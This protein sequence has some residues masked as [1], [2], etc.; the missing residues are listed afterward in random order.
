M[1]GFH[2]AVKTA[3][4]HFAHPE[5]SL[6]A[7]ADE[8]GISKQ[9]VKKRID[10]ARELFKTY[11]QEP[12]VTLLTLQ[13]RHDDEIK[14]LREIAQNLRAHLIVAKTIIFLLSSFKEM[15]KQFFPKMELRRFAPGQKTY[16][17]DMCAKFLR[18]GGTIKDFCK[19]IG[20][21]YETISRWQA[22]Y[23][24]YGMAGLVDKKTRPHNFYRRIP[25]WLKEKL[26]LLF[27]QYP[28][29]TPYQYYKYIRDNPA[30]NYSLSLVTITKFKEVHA[31]KSA[32]EKERIKKRWAFAP[33]YSVWTVDFTCILKTP[34]YK[35]QLLTVSDQRSRFWFES[36]LF[37]ETSTEKVMDH[38]EDLFIKYGKPFMIKADNGPEFKME[39]KDSLNE[40]S[41]YLLNSPTYYGQFCG[42]HERIHR[43]LKDYISDFSSHKNIT[44]LVGEINNFTGDYNHHWPHEYLENKTPAE[45]FYSNPD[46]VP[47]D[48]EVVTPYEKDGELR[49]KF[50]GR[51]GQPSRMNLQEISKETEK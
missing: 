23:E 37:L 48:V 8:F 2:P 45:I 33:N 1:D 39:C 34:H 26:L 13:A 50:T 32:D 42:A 16:I 22:A 25:L 11:G 46:F 41:V 21:S 40:L 27:L 20:K 29:W 36:A 18:V 7:L 17:L 3:I 51:D 44:R 15:V 19:A 43:T 4:M 49:M 31:Q 14:K 28:A 6:Q 47:K 9:A 10:N 38:L 30:I 12:P 35:L 24:R 5:K